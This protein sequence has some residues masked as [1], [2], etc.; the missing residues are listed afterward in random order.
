MTTFPGLYFHFFVSK[1]V[2]VFFSHTSV[3]LT[4]PPTVDTHVRMLGGADVNH[5]SCSQ[6]N[7]PGCQICCSDVLPGVKSPHYRPK[8]KPRKWMRLSL[9][10][11]QSPMTLLPCCAHSAPLRLQPSPIPGCN[12]RTTFNQLHPHNPSFQQAL[13]LLLLSENPCRHPPL[14]KALNPF[15]EPLKR[16]TL[17]SFFPIACAVH[18]LTSSI[19]DLRLSG[20]LSLGCYNYN[21]I[22]LPADL[23]TL[24]LVKWLIACN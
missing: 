17:L 12:N 19:C 16:D 7:L 14:S 10:Y 22:M 20:V 24:R 6:V 11:F 23:L 13:K 9:H 1:L 4:S 5:P 3:F 2:I 8:A 18:A 15:K 21:R